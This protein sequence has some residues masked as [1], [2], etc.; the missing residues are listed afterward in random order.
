MVHDCF[1]VWDCHV[2][3]TLNFKFPLFLASSG[4]SKSTRVGKK[5]ETPASA[6]KSTF[7]GDA[8]VSPGGAAERVCGAVCPSVSV[9]KGSPAEELQDP[10]RIHLWRDLTRTRLSHPDPCFQHEGD[11]CVRGQ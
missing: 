8:G 11:S 6:W 3:G 10:S 5:E 4:K 9:R 1:P 7:K 2:R